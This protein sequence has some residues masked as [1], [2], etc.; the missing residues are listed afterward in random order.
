MKKISKQELSEM[1]NKIAKGSKF[2]VLLTDSIASVHGTNGDVILGLVV[3]CALN[4]N[5]RKVI[6]ETVNIIVSDEFDEIRKEACEISEE[7]DFVANIKPSNEV[8]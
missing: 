2:S 3:F 6:L 4:E 8:N 5:F 7:Y 1:S